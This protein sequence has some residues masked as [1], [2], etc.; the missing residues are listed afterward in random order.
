M[1]MM[2]ADWLYKTAGWLAQNSLL[3][4]VSKQQLWCEHVTCKEWERWTRL[5]NADGWEM[6]QVECKVSD[7]ELHSVVSKKQHRHAEV[8]TQIAEEVQLETHCK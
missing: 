6:Y 7:D 3:S 8:S 5:T 4:G 1:H 2:T